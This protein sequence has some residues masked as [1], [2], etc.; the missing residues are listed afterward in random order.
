MGNLRRRHKDFIKT[1]D[2]PHGALACCSM[3]AQWRRSWGTS[4]TAAVAVALVFLTALLV[5]A[6]QPDQ[7]QPAIPLVLLAMV[8]TSAARFGVWPGLAAAIAAFMAYNFLFVEPYFTLQVTHLADVVTLAVFLLT[9]G[10]TGWLAGRLRDEADSSAR[11]AEHLKCLSSLTTQLAHSLTEADALENLARQSHALTS[12]PVL[13]LRGGADSIVPVLPFPQGAKLDDECLPIA[14]RAFSYKTVQPPAAYGSAGRQIAFYPV[15]ADDRVEHVLAAAFPR[16]DRNSVDD[17]DRTFRQMAAQTSEA[18]ERIRRSGEAENAHREAQTEQLRSG[19]LLSLSHDLRTP[20]AGILGSVS[21]LREPSLKLSEAAR[22]DLLAA[23][24]EETRRLSRYVDD[25]LMLTRLKS[26]LK[27][28]LEIVDASEIA[29]SALDRARSVHPYAGFKLDLP[30][31]PANIETDALL[32]EQIF[33]NLLDNAAKH[34]TDGGAIGLRIRTVG[35]RFEASV[36]D[37]G[38]G[39]P[40]A[41]AAHIFDPLFRGEDSAGAGLGLAIVKSAAT[42]LGFSVSVVSP[43]EGQRGASFVLSHKEA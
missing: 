41:A 29:Y 23:A 15:E 30:G 1:L 24:E 37:N 7:P 13:L 33:F 19:L 27:P 14:A 25:L 28:K 17:L 35:S 3:F 4:T 12:G 22:A 38:R 8:L 10:L 20:L 9:A 32:M 40:P 36:T 2:F 21:S 31:N 6:V 34:A 5:K 43:V 18:L 16:S 11:R 39:L 42:V 26:G